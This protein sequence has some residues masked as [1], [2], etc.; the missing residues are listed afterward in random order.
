M[1][2]MK[3]LTLGAV[4][5]AVAL[6]KYYEEQLEG[7]QISR[8]ELM[9]EMKQIQ[10]E[11]GRLNDLKVLNDKFELTGQVEKIDL[12]INGVN[13]EERIEEMTGRIDV[14]RDILKTLRKTA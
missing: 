4:V 13:V 6:Y 14:I 7:E 1:S 5:G 8:E 10:Q 3:V 9:D 11:L 12:S 2:L